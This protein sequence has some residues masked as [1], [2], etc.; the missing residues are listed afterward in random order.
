MNSKYLRW[1]F[2]DSSLRERILDRLAGR[3]ALP[4]SEMFRSYWA[5]AGLPEREVIAALDLIDVEFRIDPGL[6]RPSDPLD[7]LFSPP[8]TRHPWRWLTYHSM[9]GDRGNEFS[10]QLDKRLLRHN[11]REYWPRVLT[12]DEFVRAWCGAL[13]VS[14]GVSPA[15]PTG[16]DLGQ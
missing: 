8:D 13:P 11:T 14:R 16:L 6:F 3:N 9:C 2:L 4:K 1:L 7:I 10:Y 12:V 15:A 5:D